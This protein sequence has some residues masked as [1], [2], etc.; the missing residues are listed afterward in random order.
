MGKPRRQGM[1]FDRIIPVM[2][3][4][5]A[6]SAA[7]AAAALAHALFVPYS[8]PYRG[9]VRCDA[10]E[11]ILPSE[12]GGGESRIPIAIFDQKRLFGSRG[13][14]VSGPRREYR[15]PGASF[16]LLG[17]SLGGRKLAVLR[18]EAEKKDY[19]VSEGESVAGFDVCSIGKDR[20][21]L[22]SGEK[23]L[24]LTK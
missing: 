14:V 12:S 15:E 4:C 9:D 13:S 3:V 24:E 18:E 2:T 21:V 20:V 6:C 5:L 17:V 16:V 23:T 19:Y 1:V 8:R 7:V 11:E 10:A 22:R